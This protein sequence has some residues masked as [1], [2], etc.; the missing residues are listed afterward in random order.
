MTSLDDLLSQKANR[1]GQLFD[2]VP[3]QVQSLQLQHLADVG[4]DSPDAVRLPENTT[5]SGAEGRMDD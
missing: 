4:R 1:W 2:G 5:R 3:A